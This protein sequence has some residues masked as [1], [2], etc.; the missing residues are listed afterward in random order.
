MQKCVASEIHGELPLTVDLLSY[1][2]KIKP[3]THSCLCYK[4][5]LSGKYEILL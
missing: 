5:L 3:E 4:K 1:Q 2:N